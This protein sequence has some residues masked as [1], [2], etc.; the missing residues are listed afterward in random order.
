MNLP[1][2]IIEESFPPVAR[3]RLLSRGLGLSNTLPIPIEY[4]QE[5][6]GTKA[7]LSCGN[8]HDSCPV[9]ARDAERHKKTAQRTSMALENIVGDDCERCLYCVLSCP[10]VDPGLKRFALDAKLREMEDRNPGEKSGWLESGLKIMLS[11]LSQ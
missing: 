10:Q 3:F 8:C 1:A 4:A 7:C 6:V 5:L 9:L 11:N 2:R